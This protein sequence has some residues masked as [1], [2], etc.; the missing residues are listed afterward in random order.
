MSEEVFG[1]TFEEASDSAAIPAVQSCYA[2]VTDGEFHTVTGERKDGTPYTNYSIQLELT[3]KGHANPTYDGWKS[4]VWL[5][6]TGRNAWRLQRMASQCS[7][8]YIQSQFDTS[9]PDYVGDE[10]RPVFTSGGKEVW[11]R[12]CNF[13]LGGTLLDDN[14]REY[15]SDVGG[16]LNK[17]V[18]I[19]IGKPR[20]DKDGI[21]RTGNI[22]PVKINTELVESAEAL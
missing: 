18:E 19:S 7:L 11:D 8:D 22:T 2:T 15:V 3:I 13:Y 9:H 5:S 1:P 14:E 12:V 10:E 6:M 21:D 17:T 16:L 4:L 20:K